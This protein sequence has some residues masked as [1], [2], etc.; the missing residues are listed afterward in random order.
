VLTYYDPVTAALINKLTHYHYPYVLLVPDSAEAARLQDLG[1]NVLVGDLDNPD[2]YRRARV[3]KADLVATTVN[4]VV[5]TSVAFTVRELSKDVP[6]IATANDVASVDILEL[7]GASYVLQLGDMLGKS[8]ARRIIAGDAMSHVIGQFDQLLIAEATPAGTPLLGKSLRESRLRELAGISVVGV[9]DRGHFET[10]KAE[11]RIGSHTVLVLAGSQSQLDSYD[12]LFSSYKASEA[13][14]VILGGGRVGR[15]TG[16]ALAERGLDYR[17]VE[18]M[19]ERIRNTDKYVLGNAAELEVLK[20]AGIMDAPAVVITTHHDET[21]AYLTVYCR[22]LRPDSQIIGR[23]TRERNVS[24]LHRAGADFVMSYASMGAN[25]IFNLLK[26]SDFL[27][28]AEGLGLFRMKVPSALVGKTIAQ[29]S[30]PEETGC[31]LVAIH[32]DTTME[33]N[34]DPARSL[35][36]DTEIILIGSAEGENR[37][38]ERYGD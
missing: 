13:P 35:R 5:N 31:S 2:T 17:I 16:R 7:A 30:I 8:L 12:R 20:K 6:V 34:P 37:F 15:A 21:N 26:R 29:T 1:L 3:D 10:A 18:Q 4:D 22:R 25:I 38:L 36:A 23:A 24:T 9:W 32:F 27:M 19:P 33:I 14:V 28:V 11:T